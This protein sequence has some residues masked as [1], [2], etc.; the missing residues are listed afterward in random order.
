MSTSSSSSGGSHNTR[1][2]AVHDGKLT[3]DL[4]RPPSRSDLGYPAG[5]NYVAYQNGFDTASGKPIDTTLIL[6]AGTLHIPAS[7]V[8]ADGGN[9]LDATNDPDHLRPPQ[10]L[11]VSR[12]FASLSDARASLASDAALLGIGAPPSGGYEY[13]R[14][15]TAVHDW[16]SVVVTMAA[17]ETDGHLHVDYGF[18]FGIYHNPVRDRIEHDG[19]VSIDLTRLPS[20]EDLGFLPTYNTG[21][22]DAEPGQKMKVR[23][24]LPGGTI[25]REASMVQSFSGTTEDPDYRGVAQPHRSVFSLSMTTTDKLKANLLAD[26]PI[27]GLEPAQI[28][29]AFKGTSGQNYGATLEG[30]STAAYSV[31][32][33][34][35]GSYNL[36]TL[37]EATYEFTYHR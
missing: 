5:Q 17:P 18:S 12:N 1:G 19:V 32:V 20:R 31:E 7:I 4:R 33:R 16:L 27:L 28:L 30:K 36:G 22:L 34:F 24:T 21:D 23:L 10:N 29:A 3:V 11:I 26:A 25:E 14:D 2:T 15:Y 13:A 6:P 8:S 35:G 9:P 37:S